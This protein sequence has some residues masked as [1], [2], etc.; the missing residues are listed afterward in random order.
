MSSFFS[1]IPTSLLDVPFSNTDARVI[2]QMMVDLQFE[3]TGK[4]IHEKIKQQQTGASVKAAQD[5][6]HQPQELWHL[7]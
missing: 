2:I 7:T 4:K 1:A 3:N 5:F 6:K